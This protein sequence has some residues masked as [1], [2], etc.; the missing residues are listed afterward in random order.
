MSK[1]KHNFFIRYLPAYGCIA[2]GMIYGAIGVIAILSFLKLRDGGA[3]EN[4]LM[5]LLNQF[6][7]GKILIII[8]L[9]GS[10][11]YVIWRFYEAVTDPYHYGNGTPGLAK[12]A[13]ISLSTVADILI[14]FSAFRF[15]FGIGN[16]EETDQLGQQREM[17]SNLLNKSWGNE[18][19]ISIGVIYLLTALVQ[20]LYGVT[21]GYR[22]RLEVEE[23]KPVPRKFVHF[24]GITGYFA[25]GIILGITG[26]F[27][28]K[29]GLTGNPGLVVDTDKA[30]DFIGDNIGH[31][32]FIL[33]AAGTI[34]YGIFMFVLGTAYDIDR[35]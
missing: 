29:A 20:F 16:T 3:D 25:R 9:A 27:Y 35:D 26:F 11:C 6:T 17:V 8:I 15:L 30:F 14:V 2:T 19:I 32:A 12:R 24:L 13:G 33:V 21:R 22:E 4:R 31:P 7:W 10:L 18:A 1:R 5:A 28:L 34:F 23:F